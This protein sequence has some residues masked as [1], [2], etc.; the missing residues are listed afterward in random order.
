LN[1]GSK[2]RKMKNLLFAA[3][4]AAPLA[5]I[6]A[7][8]VAGTPVDN[9]A[10]V[11]V[12]TANYDAAVGKL[13]SVVR[14]APWD[15]AALINLAVAYRHTGRTIEA[16]ALYRRVLLLEDV[17]LDATDGSAISSRE[18]ARRALAISPQLSAR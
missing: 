14:R 4:V 5:A 13:E 15:E 1:K 16:N 9:Y 7:N 12:Q 11:A 8:G 18:V 2:E 17:V 6:P 3:I 10:V